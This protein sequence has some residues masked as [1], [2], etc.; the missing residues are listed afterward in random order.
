MGNGQ[1]IQAAPNPLSLWHLVSRDHQVNPVT[2]QTF[3][4]FSQHHKKHLNY[5][6]M[7]SLKHHM[8]SGPIMGVQCNT[9]YLWYC[10][11]CGDRCPQS[12][13]STNFSDYRHRIPMPWS[14]Q[15]Q[16]PWVPLLTEINLDYGRDKNQARCF[17]WYVTYPQYSNINGA[18]TKP[19]FS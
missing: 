3:R 6:F 1:E 9:G 8:K 16:P 4:L 18:L 11:I 12:N 14:Y 7:L 2:V 17:L 19:L 5:F 13:T 10:W 15:T